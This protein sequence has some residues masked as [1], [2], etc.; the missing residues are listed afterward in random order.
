MRAEHII[1]G[2]R[3]AGAW[4]IVLE[5]LGDRT[6]DLCRPARRRSVVYDEPGDVPLRIG[7]RCV[8][9]DGAAA[10][11]FDGAGTAFHGRPAAA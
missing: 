3:H 5:R 2:W 7:D 8:S 9:I 6:L 10:H 11:L 1:R 4:S